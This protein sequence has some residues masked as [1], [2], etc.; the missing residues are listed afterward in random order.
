[1]VSKT[2]TRSS[3]F[4]L[5]VLL[6]AALALFF[7]ASMVAQVSGGTLSG[8]VTDPNCGPVPN[9]KL[10]IKNQATGVAVEFSSDSAGLYSAPNLLPG[11]YEITVSASEFAREELRG[12]TL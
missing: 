7:P 2:S 8:T 10:S 11:T 5:A 4:G 9:A 3:N 1:M 12:V 6:A